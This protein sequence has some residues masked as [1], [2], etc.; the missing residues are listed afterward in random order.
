M[1]SNSVGYH[2]SES[3][4]VRFVEWKIRVFKLITIEEI[5]IFIIS[6]ISKVLYMIYFIPRDIIRVSVESRVL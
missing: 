3:A 1:E 6:I 2:K 4:G 5:V